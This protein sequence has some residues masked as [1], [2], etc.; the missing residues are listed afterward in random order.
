MIKKYFSR[1]VLITFNMVILIFIQV[2]ISGAIVPILGPINNEVSK[3]TVIGML[4]N[5]DTEYDSLGKRF[6]WVEKNKALLRF[7]NDSDEEIAGSIS[8]ILSRNPCQSNVR[9][10]ILSGDKIIKNL[11]LSQDE[12]KVKIGYYEIRPHGEVAVFL[13]AKVDADCELKNGDKRNL[14]AQIMGWEFE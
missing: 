14:T 11:N 3:K 2:L 5:L 12:K 10:L 8:L 4:S 13:S 7:T 1:V 6:W 9:V